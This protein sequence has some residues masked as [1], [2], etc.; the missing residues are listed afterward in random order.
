MASL[1]GS[2]DNLDVAAGISIGCA[3]LEF[4]LPLPTAA[5][6]QVLVMGGRCSLSGLAAWAAT[7]LSDKSGHPDLSMS[8]LGDNSG[9][10]GLKRKWGVAQQRI[11]V[12]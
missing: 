12:A 9:A 3:Q 11:G 4:H 7:E 1:S 2:E 6:V 8:A 5:S 10:S